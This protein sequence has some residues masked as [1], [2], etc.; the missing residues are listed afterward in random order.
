MQEELV[1]SN[2]LLDVALATVEKSRAKELQL[3]APPLM[4]ESARGVGTLIGGF[5]SDA[6][7]RSR[8]DKLLTNRFS[9]TEPGEIHVVIESLISEALKVREDTEAMLKRIKK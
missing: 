5:E 1:A 7:N 6:V 8:C 2:L 3:S 4:M 9:K